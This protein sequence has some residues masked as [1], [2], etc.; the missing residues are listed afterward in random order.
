MT[1]AS[2][3]GV[4]TGLTCWPEERNTISSEGSSIIL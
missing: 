3:I 1:I 4:L 2:L